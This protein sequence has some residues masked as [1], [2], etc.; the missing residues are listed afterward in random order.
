MAFSASSIFLTLLL[1]H[2]AGDAFTMQTAKNELRKF[3][4]GL[5]RSS[6]IFFRRRSE[7][8][9]AQLGE[10]PSSALAFFFFGNRVSWWRKLLNR[11]QFEFDANVNKRQKSH[12]PTSEK[13]GKEIPPFALKC[14]PL[15]ACACSSF[16]TVFPLSF[17]T[18]ADCPDVNRHFLWLCE[19][20]LC[21]VMR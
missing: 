21:I 5:V 9:A 8:S 16:G 18:I 17:S 2:F 3:V 11:F 19:C 12:S 6:S 10:R 7:S 14:P 13:L 4:V 1:Q 15:C 20:L